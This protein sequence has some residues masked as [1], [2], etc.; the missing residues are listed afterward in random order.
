MTTAPTDYRTPALESAI[1]L[2]KLHAARRMAIAAND[3]ARVTAAEA[4]TLQ[5]HA[6]AI[7]AE[8]RTHLQERGA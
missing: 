2:R 1:L 6:D 5:A 7:Q 8:Y 3:L 4:V